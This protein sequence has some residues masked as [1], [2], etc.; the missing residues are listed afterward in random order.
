MLNKM[1]K[2]R[3]FDRMNRIILNI[4]LIFSKILV[5]AM[6]GRNLLSDEHS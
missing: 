2:N 6:P 5:P 1:I 3:G 4:L